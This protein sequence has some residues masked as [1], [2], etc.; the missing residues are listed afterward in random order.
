MDI[1][2]KDS[3][4]AVVSNSPKRVVLKKGIS[5]PIQIVKPVKARDLNVGDQVAFKVA[6]DIF[7]D[8]I[9]VIPNGT[10]VKGTVYVAKKSSAFGTKGKLG[11]IIKNIDLPDGGQIPLMNG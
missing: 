11:I 10:P 9:V 5:V 3:P 2:A 6:Q 4:D 7:S 1:K 8:G